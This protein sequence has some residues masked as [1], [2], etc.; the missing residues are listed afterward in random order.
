MST[1]EAR[2][3]RAAAQKIDRYTD[4]GAVYT[5]VASSSP[6]QPPHGSSLTGKRK[7]AGAS[8]SSAAHASAAAEQPLPSKW[9]AYFRRLQAIFS[10]MR[11]LTAFVE[12]YE[13]EGWRGSGGGGRSERGEK[14]KPREELLEARRELVQGQLRMRQLL[15]QVDAE[16]AECAKYNTWPGKSPATTRAECAAYMRAHG[17]TM[18]AAKGTLVVEVEQAVPGAQSGRGSDASDSGASAG[19]SGAGGS[20]DGAASRPG[21]AGATGAS[22]PAAGSSGGAGAG[23]AAAA[24]DDDDDDGIS[25]EEIGCSRCGS[26]DADDD[27]D[28][29][30]C[31]YPACGLALHMRCCDPPMAEPPG[32]GE[33]EDW[34]CPRVRGV[35]CDRR[36]GR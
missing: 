8:S 27:N 16:A 26:M 15:Q 30:L 7:A 9:Q 20:G 14:L 33:D 35:R 31:D 11:Y 17:L 4:D 23:S 34:Y 22:S 1:R 28:I 18:P 3:R 19:C 5:R 24:D 12:A 13:G 10:K 36:L 25:A 21:G 32:G 29:L 6:K 2:P